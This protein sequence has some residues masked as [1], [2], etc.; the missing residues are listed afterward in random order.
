MTA[1]GFHL[2]GRRHEALELRGFA[3]KGCRW[4]DDV[5]DQDRREGCGEDRHLAAGLDSQLGSFLPGRHGERAE[6]RLVR[7]R[8]GKRRGGRVIGRSPGWFIR[9]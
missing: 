7:D 8:T 9:G 5:E 1:V 4:A 2:R 6:R 3:G